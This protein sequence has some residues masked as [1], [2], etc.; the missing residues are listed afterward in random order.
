MKNTTFTTLFKRI[1]SATL[2]IATAATKFVV[3]ANAATT[4]ST[5]KASLASGTYYDDKLG[6]CEHSES[7]QGY[8]YFYNPRYYNTGTKKEAIQ[9]SRMCFGD[10]SRFEISLTT[11]TKG[12]QIYFDMEYISDDS[13]TAAAYRKATDIKYSVPILITENNK[14]TAY[15]VKTA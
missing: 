7:N 5:P 10:D 13:K 1:A 15:A 2:A 8:H 14:I 9:N 3:P 4:V 6:S 11:S 12:A